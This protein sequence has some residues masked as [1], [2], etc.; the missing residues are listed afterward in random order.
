MSLTEAG[1]VAAL[2]FRKTEAYALMNSSSS[3]IVCATTV[4]LED[5][6]RRC[7]QFRVPVG[8]LACRVQRPRAVHV[9][10]RSHLYMLVT[11]ALSLAKATTRLY[12][13]ASMA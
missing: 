11:L 13:L 5:T 7:G 12:Q 9:L 4:M 10:R 3:C 6:A 1:C 8:A 2:R